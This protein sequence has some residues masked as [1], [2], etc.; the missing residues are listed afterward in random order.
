MSKTLLALLLAGGLA[1]A[2]VA[3]G[4]EVKD[5]WR[6]ISRITV[7]TTS[8]KDLNP[9]ARQIVKA[10]QEEGVTV[11]ISDNDPASQRKLLD[12]LKKDGVI[13]KDS[14]VSIM[15]NPLGTEWA[16]DKGP[17]TVFR[18]GRAGV[19]STTGSG[20]ESDASSAAFAA[21]T[22][23]R[24]EP[25]PRVAVPGTTPPYDEPLQV[26][27]GDWM[28]TGG[29]RTL[30]TTGALYDNN[31]EGDLPD[32]A[33]VRKAVNGTLESS[34]GIDKVIELSA[35]DQK[36]ADPASGRSYDLTNAHVDLQARTLPNGQVIVA[37]VPEGDPQ[38]AILDANAAKLAAEGQTVIR[39]SNAP[40][41]GGAA[42]PLLFRTYTNA[43]FINDTVLIPSYGDAA[44]DAAAKAAYEKALPGYRIVPVDSADAIRACGA[45]R[46][47][48]RELAAAAEFKRGP[49]A[50]S[51]NAATVSFDAQ[52]GLLSISR[53]PITF[54]GGP[55]DETTS[56]EYAL[57]LLLDGY[58]EFD[59]FLF[60][61]L[62]SG[63]DEYTFVDGRLRLFGPGDDLLLSADVPALTFFG[64]APVDSLQFSGA[65]AGVA[66]SDGVP[67][68]WLD[69]F[70]SEVLNDPRY[71]PTL[72]LVAALDLEEIS[73]GFTTTFSGAA[74]KEIGATGSYPVP[75]PVPVPS[76]ALLLAPAVALMACLRRRRSRAAVD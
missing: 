2:A 40:Q 44:A 65:L 6:R 74:L 21:E 3:N 73:G 58:L 24:Q 7:S 33:D 15:D 34:F 31:G 41:T 61:P 55:N 39:V 23:L 64:D 16:R 70:V 9:L 63:A 48:A 60:Q 57:D 53:A 17:I 28:T 26:D 19:A 10:A 42:D 67:S 14:D 13:Q 11:V 46:C 52:S 76:S 45:L 27:G 56:D 8:D 35:L 75:A 20:A 59:N 69:D 18:D 43:L 54:L 37:D 62:M 32:D 36:A 25:T 71:A 22:G 38:K 66:V 68:S 1:G 51:K 12:Q 5:E 29:G 47:A 4:P 30:V 72:H 49:G 50:A